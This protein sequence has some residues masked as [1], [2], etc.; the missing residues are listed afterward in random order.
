M[1]VFSSDLFELNLSVAHTLW[2]EDDN[3]IL[4]WK[5]YTFTAEENKKN[6]K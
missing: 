4:K 1:L 6:I 3:S 2:G 5:I